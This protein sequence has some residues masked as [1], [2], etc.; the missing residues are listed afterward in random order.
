MIN[1]VFILEAIDQVEQ[2]AADALL[3]ILDP[4]RRTAF[5]DAYVDVAFDLSAVLWIVTATHAGA[6]PEP[7]RKQLAVVEL[8]GYTEQEKLAIAERHL[9]TRPFDESE[10]TAAGWLAPE[11]PALPTMGEPAAAVG[12]PAVVVE[13]GALVGPGSRAV[14]SGRAVARHRR[15]VAD[16]GVRR[17]RPLRDQRAAAGDPRPHPRSRRGRAEPEAGGDLPPRGVAPAAGESGTSR[18]DAMA[19]EGPSWS[20]GRW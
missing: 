3:D 5:R 2:E 10:R 6:I 14:V 1:P 16:G 9:L 13:R 20:G 17:W 11:S 19:A 18:P 12:T 15:G 8:P 7:V 4:V